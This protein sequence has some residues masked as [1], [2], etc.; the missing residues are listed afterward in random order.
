VVVKHNVITE[1]MT[2]ITIINGIGLCHR[3]GR[4]LIYITRLWLEPCSLL[5]DNKLYFLPFTRNGHEI[6]N[7]AHKTKREINKVLF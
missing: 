4:S 6:N 1:I 3:L 7:N 5:G 2:M